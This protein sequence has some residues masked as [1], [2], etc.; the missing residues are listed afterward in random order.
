MC[1]NIL[2]I[3]RWHNYR[4]YR[5]STDSYLIRLVLKARGIEFKDIRW[6][7]SQLCCHVAKL[8][9]TYTTSNSF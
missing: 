7:S 8:N 5:H 1:E 4:Q 2:R 3:K 6:L 9:I